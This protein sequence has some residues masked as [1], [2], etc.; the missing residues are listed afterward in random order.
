MRAVIQRVQYAKVTVKDLKTGREEVTGA[1]EA[2][3]MVLIGIGPNDSE[4]EANW[5]SQKLSTLRIFEDEAGKMNLSLKDIQGSIL[6]VSQFTLYGDC[7]R[8]RRPSFVGAAPPDLAL[9]LFNRCV[10]LIK[11]QGIHCEIGKFGHH[12]EVS[13]MNDGPV[14]LILDTEQV[15]KS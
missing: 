3:L 12:M 5:L 10:Q 4:A 14:T 9:P 7:K 15:M 2:G 13:L 1:I 11:D 8:G 6:A